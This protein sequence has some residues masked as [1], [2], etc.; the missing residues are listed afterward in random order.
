MP[1]QPRPFSANSSANFPK[2]EKEVND[3][4]AAKG[5]TIQPVNGQTATCGIAN[6]R[7]HEPP[8]R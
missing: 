6:G 5:D 3:W 1:T 4:F 2:L 7:D 8:R